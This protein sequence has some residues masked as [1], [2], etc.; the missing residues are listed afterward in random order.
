MVL[1]DFIKN[2][3]KNSRVSVAL[4]MLA[5][6]GISNIHSIKTPYLRWS[7]CDRIFVQESS[8]RLS[9]EAYEE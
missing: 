6:V 5:A 2:W 8:L 4:N 3:H 1:A 7:H 9:F